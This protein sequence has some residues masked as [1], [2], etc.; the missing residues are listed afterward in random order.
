M[1]AVYFLSKVLER[2]FLTSSYG[3][4][5]PGALDF[6][7][8][9]QAQEWTACKLKLELYIDVVCKTGRKQKCYFY[10]IGEPR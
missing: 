5:T 8:Q 3:L 6:A 1:V 4:T 9:N 10:L 2:F 7:D